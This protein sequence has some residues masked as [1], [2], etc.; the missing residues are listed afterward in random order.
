MFET[1]DILSLHLKLSAET[2]GMVGK[3]DLAR[4]KPSALLVN[5]SRAG[6]VESGALEKALT[7]GRPGFAAVD[8]YEDE[9][10]LD[11]PLLHLPNALCTPHLG[12][13]EK[14]SYENLFSPAFDQLVAFANGHPVNIVNS[15]VLGNK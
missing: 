14:N 12:Y 3:A 9:P 1:A 6:L 15:E 13:V 2:Q 11:H 10:A 4:M 7:E 5:T 8:V